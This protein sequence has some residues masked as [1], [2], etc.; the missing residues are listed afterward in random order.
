MRL[1]AAKTQKC[2][3]FIDEGRPDCGDDDTNEG[4]GDVVCDVHDTTEEK[5]GIFADNGNMAENANDNNH[6]ENHPAML[7]AMLHIIT[8]VMLWFLTSL[9]SVNDCAAASGK[10]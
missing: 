5:G 7:F 9:L 6:I 8:K 2:I 4:G 3:T 10:D 1:R